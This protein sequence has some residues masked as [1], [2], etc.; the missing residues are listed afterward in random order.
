MLWNIPLHYMKACHCDWLNKELK[1]HLLG[2]KRLGGTT[3]NRAL[4]RKKEGHQSSEEE[5]G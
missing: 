2:R 3:G 1:G 5:A 4:E